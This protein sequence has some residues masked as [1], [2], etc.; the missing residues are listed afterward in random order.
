[1]RIFN[2]LL[3]S[4]LLA[5]LPTACGSAPSPAVVLTPPA[6]SVNI[7]QEYCPSIQIQN[8]MEIAWTNQDKVDHILWIERVDAQ[9]NRIDA[10]GT[11]LLQPGT[12]FTI[13]LHDPGE[14]TYYCSADRKSF[15][16]ITVTP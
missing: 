7:S 8:G 12:M 15:G 11:D 10:G 16:T 5:V 4:V 3:V 6:I 1:M 2:L 14:Y 13:T 9:G